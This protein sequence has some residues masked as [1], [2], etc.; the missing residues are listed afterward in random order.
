VRLSGFFIDRT[1]V[2]NAEFAR[3]VAATGYKPA[4]AWKNDGDK[5]P[6]VN[7]TWADAGAYARWAGK[8]LPTEAEWEYAARGG[9]ERLRFPWG[10]EPLNEGRRAMNAAGNALAPVASFP[11]NGYGLFDMA[12]NAAEWC[13]DWYLPDYYK[14]TSRGKDSRTDPPGPSRSYD[15]AEPGVWK[16]VVRGGSWQSAEND[17]RTSARGRLGPDQS[18]P[19]VGFRCVRDAR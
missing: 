5:L 7:V 1:E 3:F 11:A 14:E 10:N 13:A 4:G 6:A 16:R 18:S 12:G 9:L 15:P 19:A 8:R 2:T 17:A